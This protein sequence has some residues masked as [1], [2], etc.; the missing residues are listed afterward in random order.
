MS[1]LGKIILGLYLIMLN[2]TCLILL[3][4]IWP[5]IREIFSN[6]P[7]NP[8]DEIRLMLISTVAGALGS[9]VVLLTSFITYVGNRNL[10]KSWGWWYFAWPIAGMSIGLFVYIAIRGGLLKTGSGISVD[11]LNP[12]T[13]ATVAV[14]GGALSRQILF[15]LK[16]FAERQ[17]S[18]PA[19]PQADHLHRVGPQESISSE[20]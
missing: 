1:R 9:C 20:D 6:L 5:G 14:L 18:V 3:F 13:V 17:L 8:P 12:Y 2:L 15:K 10:I 7:F 4:M 19:R 11:V 16:E